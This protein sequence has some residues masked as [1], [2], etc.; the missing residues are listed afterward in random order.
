MK[1]DLSLGIQHRIALRIC[2]CI[3]LYEDESYE[4]ERGSG[5]C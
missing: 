2:C 5:G 4:M 1:I 3:L